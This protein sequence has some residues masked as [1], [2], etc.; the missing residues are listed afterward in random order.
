MRRGIVIIAAVLAAVLASAAWGSDVVDRIVATV[1]GKAI[2]QSDWD[3]AAAYEAFIE[4]HAPDEFSWEKRKAALDRLID[5]EL[6]RQQAKAVDYR[7]VSAAEV[8]QHIADIRKQHGD[9]A[10][11]SAWRNLLQ[12]YG[13]TESDLREKVAGELNELRAVDSHLRPTVQIDPHSI[14][15]YYQQKLLPELRQAGAQEVPLEQVAPK[16]KELLAQ[17]KINDLL[18]TWLKNLRSESSIH[19][20]PDVSSSGGGGL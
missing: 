20:A 18:V 6:I 9:P 19:T 16:I 17:Q 13:M 4:G 5:Q 15:A 12:R 8:E 2:L 11:E 7:P 3:L 1:N 10:N 14:E